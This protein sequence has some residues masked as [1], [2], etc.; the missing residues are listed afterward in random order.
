MT[1][2]RNTMIRKKDANKRKKR[3]TKKR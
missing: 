3:T 1:M 2:K